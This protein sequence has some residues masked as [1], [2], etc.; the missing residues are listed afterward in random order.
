MR[1]I[2]TALALGFIAA[3]GA[4]AQ[5]SAGFFALRGKGEG[6][7]TAQCTLQRI[8]GRDL[9]RRMRGSRNQQQVIASRSIV[10]GQCEYQASPDGALEL[11]FDD[12]RFECPFPSP[13]G[14]CT[15]RV[16][17]AQSGR[18]EVHIRR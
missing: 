12:S 3:Q 10:G 7:W 16:E 8:G 13:S 14:A 4:S 11:S 5:S 2:I 17:A 18:F 1:T 9:E 6:G 15:L